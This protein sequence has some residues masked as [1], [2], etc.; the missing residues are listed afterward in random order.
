MLLLS[1]TVYFSC[2]INSVVAQETVKEFWP[3]IDVWLRLSPQWRFSLFVPISKNIETKYREGN[4]IAQVDYAFGK[5]HF[6]HLVRLYDGNRAQSI[7]PFLLRGGYLKAK[8]L[9]DSG[10]AYN[11]DMGYIEFHLR[12]PLKGNILISHRVRPELRWIGGDSVMSYRLR[13]RL[14]IEKEIS[15]KKTS[16]VP[17]VNVEPYY[18][19]RYE[20]VHRVRVIGGT[21]VAWS[22]HFLMEGNITYQHDSRSSVTNLYALNIILHLFFETRHSKAH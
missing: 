19:S 22:P 17:Y 5:S 9:N 10:E 21:S 16:W 6:L 14:M 2:Q 15:G 12:N 1:L 11:E 3:E 18:D 4:L 20:T 7:K 13:Y 8:S